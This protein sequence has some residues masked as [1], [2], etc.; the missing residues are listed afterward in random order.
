ML[1]RDRSA[2]FVASGIRVLAIS[3]DT[4]WSHRAWAETLRLGEAVELL[5]DHRGEV[6]RGFGVLGESNG[7]QLADRSASLLRG[8]TVVASWMLGRDMPDVDAVI[9]AASSF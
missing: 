4:H 5:S 7:M 1:L 2:D 3:M 8:G 6:A 9:A